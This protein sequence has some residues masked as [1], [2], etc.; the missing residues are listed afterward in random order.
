[1]DLP[2]LIFW[3]GSILRSEIDILK[4]SK[5]Y[6]SKNA[7]ASRSLK[8]LAPF[9]KGYLNKRRNASRV[10]SIEIRMIIVLGFSLRFTRNMVSK[11]LLI[12]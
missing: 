9:L 4:E 12:M 3:S 8:F 6:K 7:L 11:S 2:I 1:M 5:Y 10:N